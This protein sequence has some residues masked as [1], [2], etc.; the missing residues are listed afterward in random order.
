M[1]V[2][3]IVGLLVLLILGII[4]A[5]M[6]RGSNTSTG[7]QTLVI[8]VLVVVVVVFLLYRFVGIP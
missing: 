5:S 2:P 6:R 8:V 4:A 3:L 1:T 7:T